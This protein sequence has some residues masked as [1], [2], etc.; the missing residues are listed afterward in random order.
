YP[1]ARA[2]TRKIVFHSGPT[3]SGKTY[4]VLERF[5]NSN[6][7]SYCGPFKFLTSEVYCKCNQRG[8]PCDLITGEER[9]FAN[10]IDKSPSSHVSCTVEM[11]S[12]NT[13]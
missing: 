3:N 13:P 2:F 12:V 8:C 9:N 1:E 6:Q 5:C 10:D 4:H 11:I 7:E